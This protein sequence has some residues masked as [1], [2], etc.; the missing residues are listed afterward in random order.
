MSARTLL[1]NEPFSSHSSSRDVDCYGD[2][3][4]WLN[5]VSDIS[6]CPVNVRQ[7][8]PLIA[9]LK[10]LLTAK[11]VSLQNA[12]SFPGKDSEDPDNDQY[13]GRGFGH[14]N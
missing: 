13:D 3:A 2:T 6:I 8:L 10:V 4:R 12:K 11:Q 5:A 14:H 9:T 7:R 1:R